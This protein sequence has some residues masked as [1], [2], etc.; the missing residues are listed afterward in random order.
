MWVSSLD[1]FSSYPVSRG[2]PAL[3][4]HTTGT[5]VATKRSSS[6]T[7]RSFTS[8]TLTPPIDSSRPVSRRSKPSSRPPL[9]GEQ[10]HPCPL[11]HGQDGGNRH[12]GSKPPGRYVL[13]RVTTLLSLR[14]LFC[15]QLAASSSLIG[16]LDHAFASASVVVPDTVRLP[17][18]LALFP[19]SLTRV[20]K[21]WGAPDI[22]SGAY[23]PSQ[24][25]RLPVSSARSE[26]RSHHR[27]V[28]Q[29]WLGDPLAR[30]PV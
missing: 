5:P 27:V 16:S 29:C 21:S 9:I 24:T 20:R 2:Y 11:L 15:Q 17:Y 25:A 8:S 6:R 28:F 30:V 14:K 12:R 4:S 1:A 13:L 10:P 3:R 26:S 19:A 7:I 23:R 22:F 18:A